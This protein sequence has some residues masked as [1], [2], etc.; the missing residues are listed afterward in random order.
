VGSRGRKSP[1]I[2]YLLYTIFSHSF[3]SLL[4]T[5]ILG[6]DIKVFAKIYLLLVMNILGFPLF[7]IDTFATFPMWVYYVIVLEWIG[8]A[9]LI[10]RRDE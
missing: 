9:I 6:G 5:I 10:I 3:L 4:L 7:F 2:K 8:E 1:S